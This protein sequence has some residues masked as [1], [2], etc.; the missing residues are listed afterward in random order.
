MNEG[1]QGSDRTTLEAHSRIE[2]PSR[3]W[4]F[5]DRIAKPVE[6]LS[7]SP[8]TERRSFRDISLAWIPS[9]KNTGSFSRKGKDVD[10]ENIFPQSTTFKESEEQCTPL[11]TMTPPLNTSWTAKLE[12]PGSSRLPEGSDHC[13][14]DDRPLREEHHGLRKNTL[15]SFILTNV[16]I[17]LVCLWL[18]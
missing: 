8:H 15:R 11:D 4:V 2:I 10:R 1:I 16:Y 17:P 9:R 14:S 12:P 5:N 18:S 6:G 13:E 7:L 3:W